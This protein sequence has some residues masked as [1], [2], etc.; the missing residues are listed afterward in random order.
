LIFDVGFVPP[1]KIK[2]CCPDKAMGMIRFCIKFVCC[3]IG[4]VGVVVSASAQSKPKQAFISYR[5]S[6]EHLPS[7]DSL[8]A[9]YLFESNQFDS[10]LMKKE[11]Q[12]ESCYNR[13]SARIGRYTCGRWDDPIVDSLESMQTELITLMKDVDSVLRKKQ[14]LHDSLLLGSFHQLSLDFS[15]IQ[16]LSLLLDTQPLF[17]KEPVVD[18]TNEFV[19]FLEDKKN[20]R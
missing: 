12:M 1:S 10:V 17:S 15:K 11:R 3:T 4:F 16:S 13:Y 18:L 5:L 2:I 9:D 19:L 6:L 8:Q 20:R 7:Y 14:L